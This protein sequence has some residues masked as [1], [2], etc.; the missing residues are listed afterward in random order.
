[1]KK[2]TNISTAKSKKAYFQLAKGIAKKYPDYSITVDGGAY[3]CY[4]VKFDV[5]HQ[6]K[7]IN[8][9]YYIPDHI[10]TE[11]CNE[12]VLSEI[13]KGSTEGK[14]G[15]G[16]SKA[17]DYLMGKEVM[18]TEY[19]RIPDTEEMIR[20]WAKDSDISFKETETGWSME[21]KKRA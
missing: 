9:D 8:L 12:W 4:C 7:T 1:M 5:D 10:N 14:V 11:K 13:A 18:L 2:I 15:L 3:R 16:W 17:V 21:I 19:D 20:K 6:S